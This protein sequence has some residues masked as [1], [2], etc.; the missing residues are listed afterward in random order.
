MSDIENL[1]LSY[2][3]GGKRITINQIIGKIKRAI[4]SYGLTKA[5]VIAIIDR[6]RSDPSK[7]P[8]MKKED[9]LAKLKPI[10]DIVER[11]L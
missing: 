10:R 9:K 6:I 7:L 8:L 4:E 11:V 3:R 5:D 1:I 2:L